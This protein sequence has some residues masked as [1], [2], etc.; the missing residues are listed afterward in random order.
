MLP[1]MVEFPEAAVPR[2]V[3]MDTYSRWPVA[4][5]RGEGSWLFTETGEPYLDLAGG[6]AVTVLGHAHP[7][8]TQSVARQAASLIH[9][10]NLYRIPLQEALAARLASLTGM[11]RA[12][13]CNSGAEANEAAIKLARRHAWIQGG[14]ERSLIITLTGS[15]HGRTLG[16]LSA[17]GQPRYQ[18]GFGPLVPGFTSVPPGD[19]SALAATM[20][21]YRGETCAVML[22]PVLGEGGVVPLD[23]RYLRGVQELCRQQGVL[24]IVD[25]VQTGMGRTGTFLASQAAGIHPDVVTL[26]K[27]LANGVPIGAVLA[28]ERVAAGFVPGSHGSTFGG[29]PLACAAALA[30]LDVVEKEGLPGRAAQLGE[31][32]AG[33]LRRLAARHTALARDVRGVGL[34]LALEVAVPASDVV[35]ACLE[36]HLLVTSA[37]PR[38]VR[39]L[40]A[41]TLLPSEAEEG[42]L[43]L[44]RALGRLRRTSTTATPEPGSGQEVPTDARHAAAGERQPV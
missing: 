3:L 32:L 35:R 14:T 16:A 30:T 1:D 6:I 21:S 19:L 40:P 31:Q 28:T 12:F 36:E 18:E 29:N 2:P 43:R 7:T 24:L 9:C 4:F 23:A 13:F 20:Q 25:E 44:D 38:T 8:V 42:L 5:A 11:D 33:G 39:F 37:G 17:T 27:G 26:A 10:S 41:L 34:M 22:E 15:F